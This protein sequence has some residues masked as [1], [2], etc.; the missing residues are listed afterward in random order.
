MT[1]STR[2]LSILAAALIAVSA[3]G[4]SPPELPPDSPSKMR[5]VLTGDG[6]EDVLKTLTT[7]DWDDG[8]AAA[9]ARF[10]WVGQDAASADGDLT[11]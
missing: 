10:T 5:S 7:Y 6:A 2:I 9:G 1:R 3:C 4:T 8:G 11:S